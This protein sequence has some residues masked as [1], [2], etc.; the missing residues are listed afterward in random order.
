MSGKKVYA[1]KKGTKKSYPTRH[2]S[3]TAKRPSNRFEIESDSAGVSVTAKNL[4]LSDKDFDVNNQ[5]GYRIIHFLAVFSVIAQHVKYKRCD[6]DITFRERSPR[7]VGFKIVIACPNCSDVE[8]PSSTSIRSAYEINRRIVLAMRLLGVGLNG[9]MKFCGFMELPRP[10]FQSFY[11]DIVRVMSIASSSVR[12]AS[13]KKA[14]EAKQSQSEEN[15]Q[16]EG[17]IVSGDGSW[18]KREFSLLFGITSLIGWFTGKLAPSCFLCA[19]A[20][21]RHKFKKNL[22]FLFLKN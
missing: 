2:R 14:V 6:A 10:I 19:S 1:G 11:D 18:R 22:I 3:K 8:I 12:D 17:I 5:F 21:Y 4:K 15:G 16:R 13:M 20:S 7:G 9:L